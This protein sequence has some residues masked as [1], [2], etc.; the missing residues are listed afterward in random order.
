MNMR[1][2]IAKE[3]RKFIKTEYPDLTEDKKKRLFKEI[4]RQFKQKSH[5]DKNFIKIV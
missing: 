4:A 1:N 2:K 3:I 5:I